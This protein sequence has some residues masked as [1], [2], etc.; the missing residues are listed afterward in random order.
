MIY[1]RDWSKPITCVLVTL[2][3]RVVVLTTEVIR[4]YRG[5]IW[6]RIAEQ[7]GQS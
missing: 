4:E 1:A 5:D 6:G 7:I 3:E 2:Q